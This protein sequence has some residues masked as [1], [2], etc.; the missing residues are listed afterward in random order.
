MYV[1]AQSLMNVTIK[2][3]VN[4]ISIKETSSTFWSSLLFVWTEMVVFC[5]CGD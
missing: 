5:S 4:K 1:T 2:I 3:S